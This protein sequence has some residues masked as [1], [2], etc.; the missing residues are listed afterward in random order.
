MRGRV[1]DDRD[2]VSSSSCRRSPLL[3]IRHQ[4]AIVLRLPRFSFAA[5][6]LR[7]SP[8]RAARACA[9]A[10]SKR[11]ATNERANANRILPPTERRRTS[12]ARRSGGSSFPRC[13]S[14]FVVRPLPHDFV[15]LCFPIDQSDFRP[16]TII[17]MSIVCRRSFLRRC[18]SC[19]S[20]AVSVVFAL[21][22]HYLAI[23]AVSRP[24]VLCMSITSP[25]LTSSKEDAAAAS[26]CC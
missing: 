16:T 10:S 21:A 20:R 13:S 3:F 2:L 15:F 19:G 5:R 23:F 25:A 18:S 6:L 4:P 9:A 22:I 1:P 14:F 11:G 12:D 8:H 7:R 17:S 26:W 24:L